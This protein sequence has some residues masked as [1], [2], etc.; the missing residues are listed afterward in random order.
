V[1]GFS[2]LFASCAPLHQKKRPRGTGPTA[3]APARGSF[4]ENLKLRGLVVWK[5][6]LVGPEESTTSS[7]SGT[8]RCRVF[9]AGDSTLRQFSEVM[10]AL[11]RGKV[12]LQF[13]T[14]LVFD[15]VIICNHF[16]IHEEKR[17]LEVVV[18]Y[19]TV[20]IS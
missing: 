4:C 18:L 10:C 20:S 13:G 6:R 1:P 5:S 16:R 17:G 2:H 7:P 14:L 3:F 12:K 15:C 19:R 9:R 11:L 8:C